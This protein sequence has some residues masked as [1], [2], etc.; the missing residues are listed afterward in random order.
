[1]EKLSIEK[2]R[3]FCEFT[4]KIYELMTDEEKVNSMPEEE[5]D[6]L[7]E[8]MDE[9]F[10]T[11]K[12]SDLS[13]IPF[14][15]WQNFTLVAQELELENT[16]ANI[17]FNLINIPTEVKRY[18]IELKLKGCNVRNFDFDKRAFKYTDDSFDEEFVAKA[19]EQNGTLFP[20]RRITSQD[21]K[22]R[23]RTRRL[24]LKDVKEYSLQDIITMD[25]LE[26]KSKEVA[27]K[28]GFEKIAEIDDEILDDEYLFDAFSRVISYDNDGEEVEE[29]SFESAKA[30]MFE[31]IA[32][33]CVGY[34]SERAYE[35]YS[36]NPYVTSNLPEYFVDFRE[37]QEKLKVAFASKKLSLEQVIDNYEMFKGKKFII[38]L[39][40]NGYDKLT[41]MYEGLTEEKLG[42][43]IENYPDVIKA[44]SEIQ[45][46]A[47]YSIAS[48][49][50]FSKTE[51]EIRQEIVGKVKV[52]ALKN[53]ELLEYESI[54]DLLPYKDIALESLEKDD[55]RTESMVESLEQEDIIR[56]LKERKV[57]PTTLGNRDFASAVYTFGLRP[58]LDFDARNGG[59]L[60]QNDAQVLCSLYNKFI[61]YGINNH[62]PRT[63][64]FT[65]G[66]DLETFEYVGSDSKEYTKEEFEESIRRMIIYGPTDGTM[67]DNP[68][69]YWD[70]QG[71]FRENN[72]DLYLGEN[73]PEDLA[74]RFYYGRFT[75]D[76]IRFSRDDEESAIREI[77]TKNRELMFRKSGIKFDVEKMDPEILFVLAK[78]NGSYLNLLENPN[79]RDFYR[80]FEV[81]KFD[82]EGKSLE[83][84]QAIARELIENGILAGKI[85][86]G[87]KAPEYVREN[88]P[89][90]FL[91]NDAPE[92]LKRLYYRKNDEELYRENEGK[93]QNEK[94]GEL[95]VDTLFKNPEYIEFLKGKNLSFAKLDSKLKKFINEFGEEEFFK[96]MEHDAEAIKIIADAGNASI[97]RFK[98]LLETRPDFYAQKELRE[99]DGYTEDELAL[100]LSGEETE[101]ERILQGRRLLE[102]KREKFRDFIITSPGY[103]IHCPD[104]KLDDFNFSEYKDLERLSKFDIS[105]NYRRDTAEQI[106]TSMYCFLGYGSSR[107]VMKL[108]EVSEEELEEAIRNTGIAV[109]GIYENVY[110]VQGNL[111]TLSTLFDKFG[112]MLPGGK[113]N[114]AV[115]KSLNDKLEQGYDG[116]IEELLRTCLIENEI[117]FSDRRLET[118]VKNAVD[119]NTAGK[120]DLIKDDISSYLIGN[121]QETPENIKI[122]NDILTTA[123]KRS[124][125]QKEKI[126]FVTIQEYIQKEFSRVKPDGTSFYSPHVTDHMQELLDAVSQIQNNPE[127]AEKLNLSVTDIL[128]QE[129]EKIGKGWIRKLLDIKTRLTEKEKQDLET[130]LYGE[131]STYKIDATK[132]LELKDKSEDGIEEAYALLKEMRLPGVFTF[133]KGEIMFA[134]LTH[135]YSENFKKFFLANM[136]EILSKPEYYTEFQ[137]MHNKIEAVIKDPNIYSRFHAGRYTIKE[138]LDDIQNISFDNIEQGEHELAY[139]AKKA[140]LSQEEFNIAKTIHAKMLE[141][142][143]QTVPPVE[144]KGKKYV[145]RI[146]R[147]DDPLHITIGNVTTCCQRLG[148]SQPGESSMIHSANEEN[149]SVFVVE[150]VDEYG[151]VV[152]VVAQ[153]WTWRNGDRVCFDN[154]EIPNTLAG[155]LSSNGGYDEIYRIYTS[156]AQKMIDID[157]MA[158]GKLLDEGKITREQYEALVIKEVTVGNGCDDLL[159]YV[160]E[161]FKSSRKKAKTVMPAEIGKRY[162]GVNK[163]RGLYVDSN[164]QYVLAENDE[165]HDKEESKTGIKVESISFGYVRKRDHIQKK[166]IEIHPDL[167]TRCK[168][169]N[170]RAGEETMAQSIISKLESANITVLTRDYYSEL[171]GRSLTLDFSE[172][173]DW[174]ILTSEGEKDIQINDSIL[175][176]KDGASQE[177]IKIAKMEYTKQF[178]LIA[179]QAM[180]KGKTLIVNSE[181]EGKFIDF[182]KFIERDIIVQKS[183][184]TIEVKDPE[185]LEE[186]LKSLDERIQE[187]RDKRVIDTAVVGEN[188]ESGEN[189]EHDDR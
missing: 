116:P 170:E 91:S 7:Q 30:R 86:Y 140:G 49:I 142:E 71:E 143:K 169:I 89:E 107:E 113:K 103:V 92:E 34:S 40:D 159:R 9:M 112:S 39:A 130:R 51:D 111:K 161:E 121:I 84:V 179:K 187:N 46:H 102:S 188:P 24:T 125:S 172:Q 181:R 19:I 108:P 120:M 85:P 166:D 72:P 1:M 157:K 180:E 129:K 126:N 35:R 146:L 64:I 184:G 178:L 118:I 23:L 22:E 52:Y 66:I 29:Y 134:G 174:Y 58:I 4:K 90:L 145:G 36:N 156:V 48:K 100:I 57:S 147:I 42:Y 76:D 122:L 73:I 5:I 97:E 53:K 31:R 50:D 101:N 41:D 127:L 155:E 98:T 150:E 38:R 12:N 8:Q 20:E 153:S 163:D 16:G 135:P 67:T 152:Q 54:M 82:F 83:E 15:E 138:L 131:N 47:P 60:T 162:S 114:F 160:S 27:E 171:S 133:E 3:E 81:G 32:E 63:Q 87:E 183:D 21:V 18:G 10:E 128:K 17:D 2:F 185:K 117:D 94:I 177:E 88:H 105:D 115:Y 70:I 144:H 109:S 80:F 11:L 45:G 106:I 119:V 137:K 37:D 175:L 151:N 110:S 95:T 55:Y 182:E 61:H 56:M 132:T 168:A 164:V 158:L 186:L 25:D 136:T 96:L 69:Q 176:P 189:G 78:E 14:E 123:L 93:N 65:K 173:D 139:R 165:F 154:V 79:E 62:D 99:N 148:L 104:E 149:G 33:E 43:L 74:T 26:Y 28:I 75:L 68:I 124:F 6:K 44:L 167:I 13:D 141:R 77:L 59:F